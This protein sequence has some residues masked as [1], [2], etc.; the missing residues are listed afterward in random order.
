MAAVGAWAD[1]T[2]VVAGAGAAAP[3][4]DATG[5]TGRGDA[6]TVAVSASDDRPPSSAGRSSFMRYASTSPPAA[7]GATSERTAAG[8]R[9]GTTRGRRAAGARAASVGAPPDPADPVGSELA[10]DSLSQSGKGAAGD[11]WAPC[12]TRG[13]AGGHA[14]SG[15]RAEGGA[16]AAS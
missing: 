9:R 2:H 6:T 4:A 13:Q 5:R 10:P 11:V 15:A 14:P 3:A 16:A 7:A 1:V 8:A 12:A